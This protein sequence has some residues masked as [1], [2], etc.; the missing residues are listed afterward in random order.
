MSRDKKKKK[1]LFLAWNSFEKPA[2]NVFSSF[3]EK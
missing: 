1:F 2:E 3:D